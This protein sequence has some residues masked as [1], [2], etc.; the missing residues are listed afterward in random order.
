M[1]P[2]HFSA[3]T[4]ITNNQSKTIVTLTNTIGYESQLEIVGTDY[5]QVFGGWW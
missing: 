3:L 1:I 5:F 2:A 4:R